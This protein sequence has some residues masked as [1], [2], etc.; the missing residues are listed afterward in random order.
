MKIEKVYFHMNGNSTAFNNNEQVPELQESW[1]LLYVNFLKEKGVEDIE[2]IEF[3]LPNGKTAKYIS[4][5]D[6]WKID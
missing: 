3:N 4:L 2:S 5:Y 6:N 1:F